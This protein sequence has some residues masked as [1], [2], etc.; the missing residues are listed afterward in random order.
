MKI[1]P[2]SPRSPRRA[3]DQR[4]E[5]RSQTPVDSVQL[6]ANSE[7]ALGPGFPSAP[8][9]KS[10]FADR[11]QD[12]IA[13]NDRFG[14][15]SRG[16]DLLLDRVSG[17][18]E[19]GVGIDI[20]GLL[21]VERRLYQDLASG[22]EGYKGD[23]H[24]A[25]L[26]QALANGQASYVSLGNERQ[27]EADHLM[28]LF[29][30]MSP[31]QLAEVDFKDPELGKIRTHLLEKSANKEFPVFVDTDN[32]FDSKNTTESIATGSLLSIAKR[33]NGFG[34]DF[35]NPQA[36]YKWLLTRVDSNYAKLDP[37]LFASKPEIH[38]SVNLIK[39]NLTPP[40]LEPPSRG[41]FQKKAEQ[42]KD[43]FGAEPSSKK[44]QKAYLEMMKIAGNGAAP[45]WKTLSDIADTVVGLDR[46]LLT[47]VQTY[48]IKLLSEVS[49]EQRQTLLAPVGRAWV[50]LNVLG[51][52]HSQF[53]LVSP[54]TSPMI[55]LAS[56]SGKEKTE[57]YDRAL[58]LSQAV[59]HAVNGLGLGQRRQFIDQ[60]MGEIGDK[61]EALLAREARL[62]EQLGARYRGLDVKALVEGRADIR[63]PGVKEALEELIAASDPDQPRHQMTP[64]YAEVCR[65]RDLLDW[66]ATRHARYGDLAFD[67][68]L[69][70]PEAGDFKKYPLILS[71]YYSGDGKGNV[72][73]ITQTAPQGELLGD[74]VAGKDPMK[75]SVVLEGGGGKGFAFV[76]M[77]KQVKQTLAS[78]EGEVQIDEFV[79][80][81]AGA[82]S[83]GM[84]AA[85]YNADELGQILRELDFT[86]FYSDYLWLSGGVDPKV[87]GIGRTG[88]FT[89][90]KMYQALS[91]L[92]K[93]KVPVEGRPVLFRD[94]PFK[95]RVTSTML[96]GDI[97]Q[98]LREQLTL[99][100]DGQVVF[101]SD[102]T[103]NMDVAAA[104]SCSAA[105]PGFFHSPQLQICSGSEGGKPILHRMQMMDG[106][107][108]NNFPVAEASQDEKS[109][110][111]MLPTSY[112]APSPTPGGEPISLS[113]LDF[114]SSAVKY[115]DA[116]NREQYKSFGPQLK[117]TLQAIG[118][119]G[120]GRAVLSLNITAMDGQKAPVVQG[121]D[122]KETN[123][124]LALSESLGMPVLD[125][126]EGARQVKQNLV[127]KPRSWVERQ[128]VDKLLDKEDVYSPGGTF[129][130]STEEAGGTM[131]MLAG[132]IA[133][134]FSAPGQLKHKLFEKA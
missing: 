112:Q 4:P 110:M 73:P 92:L 84:L 132:V 36:Y 39:E 90:Q 37:W 130:P 46:D 54:P 102:T 53:D 131:D 16:A 93:K 70:N 57:R 69:K 66:V 134:Q 2:H 125:A 6:S 11:L 10:N 121:T 7:G 79:G 8:P 86:T 113:T 98:E 5:S 24:P 83:A 109:F 74:K 32:S 56:R 13:R 38:E 122:R 33:E 50:N 31:Q 115:V 94:L 58:A 63:T 76:D 81:S 71:E 75:M 21:D 91:E 101:S 100:P 116:Y 119:K 49:P 133:A 65:H 78:G 62:R 108:V 77:L 72:S 3:R 34:E 9:E 44:V 26:F 42:S 55:E 41:W 114:D 25:P 15:Y 88:L 99:S 18:T 117:E 27:S 35:S 126:D 20:H 67:W 17:A 118:D 128:L 82:L 22:S 12:W 47:G 19:Q 127:S 28:L 30:G 23:G 1:S 95:L 104:L 105:I 60:L 45:N 106:G 51:S 48:W 52:D 124:L 107:V 68:V 120:Y 97:P 64:E 14:L 103:P 129:R 80:N 85:G 87:R 29:N 61:K 40:W 89:T 123:Q 96:N 111:M 59:D 43:P